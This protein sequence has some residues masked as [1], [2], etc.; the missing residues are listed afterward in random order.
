[1]F[2]AGLQGE[3]ILTSGILGGLFDTPWHGN[4]RILKRRLGQ[5]HT[6]AL[7]G[8]ARPYEY[9]LQHCNPSRVA[10]QK[11]CKHRA[12]IM[13]DTKRWG[14]SHFNIERFGQVRQNQYNHFKNRTI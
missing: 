10:Y 8:S 14:R 3:Q 7:N 13:G 9:P 2:S 1:M 4:A 5:C 12:L 11:T 6:F